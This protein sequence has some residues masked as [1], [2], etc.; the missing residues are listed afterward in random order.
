MKKIY[1]VPAILSIAA[2]NN[3]MLHLFDVKTAFL[4]ANLAENVYMKQ[5]FGYEDESGMVC[6]LNKT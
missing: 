6:K 5:S 3:M 2:L 1:V 4:Y